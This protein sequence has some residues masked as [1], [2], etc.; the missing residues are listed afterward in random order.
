MAVNYKMDTKG[1]TTYGLNN[2]NVIMKSMLGHVKK[3]LE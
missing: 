3:D 1:D 2:E